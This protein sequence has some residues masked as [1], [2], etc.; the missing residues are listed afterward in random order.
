[1]TAAKIHVYPAK[2]LEDSEVEVLENNGQE[3]EAAVEHTKKRAQ[4]DLLVE[5]RNAAID[6]KSR[7]KSSNLTA[8]V[9]EEL[10][11]Y[12]SITGVNLK[13]P[14]AVQSIFDRLLWWDEQR[15]S[16]LVLSCLEHL[17]LSQKGIL[18]VLAGLHVRA[19]ID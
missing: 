6:S 17:V 5:F 16:F 13:Q 11:H 1:M 7:K 8:E 4:N 9:N 10:R 14:H 2:E 15:Y 19:G 18:V 3:R 12:S